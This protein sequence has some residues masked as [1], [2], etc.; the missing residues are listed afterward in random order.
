MFESSFNFEAFAEFLGYF[1][2]K[3]LKMIFQ[4][5]EWL[6]KVSKSLE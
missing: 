5:K 2:D 1:A 4:T 3:L 6:E